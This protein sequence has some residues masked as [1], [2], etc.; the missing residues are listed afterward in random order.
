MK[1]NNNNRRGF[2]LAEAL[3]S[4]TVLAIAA[5]GVL[6]PFSS[7]AAVHVEGA[8]Q[9]MG[10]KLACDLMEE[11]S[12]T[13]YDSII[14]TWNDYSESQGQITKVRST[15]VY[16]DDAYAFFSRSA[17]CTNVTLYASESDRL[18]TELGIWVTVT[19]KMN[20]REITK[21][22]TLVSR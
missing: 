16:T 15:E 6:L 17:S 1:R 4:V 11:I 21:I 22:N 10:A 20:G 5:S 19:V 9:S 3:L 14:S 18:A 7:A 2:T 12:S 8:R 13:D